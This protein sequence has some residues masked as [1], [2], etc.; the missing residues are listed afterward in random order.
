MAENL[1]KPEKSRIFAR[2]FGE[3]RKRKTE[4]Q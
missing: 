2:F 3:N 4:K 1:H